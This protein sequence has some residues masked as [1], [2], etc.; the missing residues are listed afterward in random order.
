M[1]YWYFHAV[2]ILPVIG[3]LWLVRRSGLPHFLPRPAL[4][5]L[6][7]GSLA[8]FYTSPWDNYLVFRGIWTYPPDRV[9]ESLRI[10]YVPLEEYVFFILQPIL[11]GFFL[12]HF[13]SLDPKSVDLLLG[14]TTRRAR[15]RVVGLAI[16]LLLL[17]LGIWAFSHGGHSTYFGLIAVWASP[18]LGL[19]WLYGADLIWRVRRLALRAVLAPTL[20][21]WIA[22]RIA[23]EWRI[24]SVS[25]KLS[26][27][28]NVLDLPLE[29]ALFFAL[30]NVFVVQGLLL[31]F[32]FVARR[33][34][35]TEAPQFV[36]GA[37]V[38]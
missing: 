14:A 23:L 36:A 33:K 31:Y 35:A 2:F 27:G 37:P 18:V 10:G 16:S 8:F 11:T 29:E 3:A 22:D 6:I 30:T 17:L 19:Q 5:L 34:S 38:T 4:G 24:W 15:P 12:L 21:L 20:Y 25:A 32:E 28:W 7:L 13:A 9:V 26:S 1:T